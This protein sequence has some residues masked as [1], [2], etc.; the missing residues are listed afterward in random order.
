MPYLVVTAPPGGTYD[1]SAFSVYNAQQAD[2]S[3]NWG[4]YGY[5]I[6]FSNPVLLASGFADQKT[7]QAALEQ[8]LASDSVVRQFPVPPAGA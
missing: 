2:G 3:G 6:D 8:V 5:Q 4:V 1:L 7:A